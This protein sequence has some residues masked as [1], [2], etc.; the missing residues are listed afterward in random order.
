MY[1]LVFIFQVTTHQFQLLKCMSISKFAF[2]KAKCLSFFTT[3]VSESESV[4]DC[5][6][7]TYFYVKP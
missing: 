7:I 2:I 1:L 6:G 5:K 4:T 3:L